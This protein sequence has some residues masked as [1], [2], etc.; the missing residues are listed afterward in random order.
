MMDHILHDLLDE[1]VVVYIEDILIYSQTQKE[2]EILLKEVLAR[3]DKAGL[4]VNLRKS[5]FYTLV[6]EF[7]AYIILADSIK[8]TKRKVQEVQFWPLPRKVKD[9][10]EFLDFANFYRWFIKGFSK[11]AYPLT[12][13]TKKDH[14]WNWTPKC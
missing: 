12:E 1:G 4:G 14:Q 2:H 3:L 7:L 6:I 13:L 5:Y 8:M 9:I 10:Q 11:T